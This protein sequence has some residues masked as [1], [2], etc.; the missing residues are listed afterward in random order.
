MESI[1]TEKDS[2]ITNETANS[3]L[4]QLCMI[5]RCV[6]GVIWWPGFYFCGAIRACGSNFLEV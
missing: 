1:K 5:K 3:A 2:K 4:H 6:S